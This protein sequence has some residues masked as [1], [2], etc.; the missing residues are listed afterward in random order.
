MCM[1]RL[2]YNDRISEDFNS[3]SLSLSLSQSGQ[4]IQS[5]VERMIRIW[6]DRK[7]YDKSFL[8]QLE[9]LLIGSSDDGG[10]GVCVC[11]CVCVCE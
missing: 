5:S 8:K 11:V 6:R 10:G 4:K 9:Q 7:V 3:L 1:V 2:Y